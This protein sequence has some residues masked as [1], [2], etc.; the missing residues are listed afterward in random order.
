MQLFVKYNK[1]FSGTF[2]TITIDIDGDAT[3]ELLKLMIWEKIGLLP[4]KQKLYCCGKM[5]FLNTA[6]IR[7][8][9]KKESTMFLL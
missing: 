3:V 6:K 2:Q 9:F 5:G 7:D 1:L 4:S 8:V